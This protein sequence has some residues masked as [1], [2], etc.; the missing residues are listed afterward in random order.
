MIGFSREHAQKY[1]SKCSDY[2]GK[3]EVISAPAGSFLACTIFFLDD[4]RN[5]YSI[6]PAVPLGIVRRVSGPDEGGAY[7][8]FII[9]SFDFGN[10]TISS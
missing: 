7:H 8:E 9:R 6:S 1:F 4:P 5:S 10:P 2:E 3:L